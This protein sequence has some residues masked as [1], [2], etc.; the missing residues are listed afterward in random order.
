MIQT[1]QETDSVTIVVIVL[2]V[3][4]LREWEEGNQTAKSPNDHVQ[5]S[6]GEM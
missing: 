3:P 2:A 6:Y 4:F 1:F 5:M